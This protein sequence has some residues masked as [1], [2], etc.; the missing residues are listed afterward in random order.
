M[1][2]ARSGYAGAFGNPQFLPSV[3]LR[4]AADGDGDG[5][6]NI[7][8]NRA[9]TFASIANYFKDAGWRTGQPWGVRAAVPVLCLHRPTLARAAP[10]DWRKKPPTRMQLTKR[11]T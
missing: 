4:L 10:A 11:T 5:R 6:A 3:Y 9:D 2:G 7:F 8:N 1:C